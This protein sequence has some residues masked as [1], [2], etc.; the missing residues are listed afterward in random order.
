[1]KLNLTIMIKA[2]SLRKIPF[3]CFII[4]LTI[5][6][7]NPCFS[8]NVNYYAGIHLRTDNETGLLM[9]KELGRYVVETWMK[10]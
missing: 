8:Q 6:I 10:K 5:G 2:K 3:I 4:F 7:F 9:G 1:M